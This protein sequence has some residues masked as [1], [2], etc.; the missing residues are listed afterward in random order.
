MAEP[1]LAIGRP[2]GHIHIFSEEHF[3]RITKL[4]L[5]AALCL[6]LVGCVSSLLIGNQLQRQLMGAALKPL[7]GFDPNEVDLFEI[8]VVKNRMTALLGEH[9][10]PTMAVLKTAQSIQQEGALYYVL[11]RHA[12]SEV[13]Q[14]TDQ[15]AMIW[16]ADTNQMAVMLI[17]DGMPEVLS[18]QVASAKEALTPTLPTEVQQRIDQA[19]AIKK[20]F[21]TG[22]Q[23]L[24]NPEQALQGALES[25]VESAVEK[26]VESA[27]SQ[28]SAQ[29]KAVVAENTAAQDLIN[30]VQ[31]GQTAVETTKKTVEDVTEQTKIDP[32]K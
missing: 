21:D 3:M 23:A 8:P 24:L 10:E 12:P 1:A 7:V 28:G 14:Y 30:K 6:C 13:R 17:Q 20:A 15:A 31:A 9:Y 32:S 26:T 29:A 19:V 18:E 16:N 22:T 27:V 25:A 4:L 2:F 5:S 11:S